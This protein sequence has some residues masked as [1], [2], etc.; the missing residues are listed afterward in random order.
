MSKGQLPSAVKHKISAHLRQVELLRMPDLAVQGEDDVAPH[1][2]GRCDSKN[3]TAAEPE[4]PVANAIR[5][6]EP[7]KRMAQMPSEALDVVWAGKRNDSNPSLQ[8]LD[9]RV[10]L[11]QLREML[12]AEQSTQ[13]A[14]QDQDRWPPQKTA[15]GIGISLERLDVEVEVDPHRH[16]MRATLPGVLVGRE[17]DRGSR[18]SG[19]YCV[20]GQRKSCAG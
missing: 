13:V 16:I 17:P 4:S 18:P 2:A 10:E 15:G 6:G 20:M 7:E 8:P 12:Q 5:V 14:E 11:P 1:R 9:L 3:S 19:L